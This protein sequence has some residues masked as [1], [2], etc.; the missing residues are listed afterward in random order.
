MP[1]FGRF[2]GMLEL[3]RLSNGL[4]LPLQSFGLARYGKIRLD[5]D[6]CCGWGKRHEGRRKK[7]TKKMDIYQVRI[8]GGRPS[9]WC[10]MFCVRETSGETQV[11]A[12]ASR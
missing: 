10:R 9:T 8:V 7:Q 1:S 3:L 11:N 12:T 5:D 4:H 6:I 2:G